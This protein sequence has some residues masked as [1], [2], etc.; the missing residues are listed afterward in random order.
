M[1]LFMN[2]LPQNQYFQNL[3]EWLRENIIQ[4]GAQFE[5]QQEL[6][7]FVAQYLTEGR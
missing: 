4:S 7:S 6:Q 3:P 5:N 2:S 1:N